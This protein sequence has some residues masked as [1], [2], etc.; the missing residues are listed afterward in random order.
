MNIFYALIAIVLVILI[1]KQIIKNVE[2]RRMLRQMNAISEACYNDACKTK[3]VEKPKYLESLTP[4]STP[5]AKKVA[6]K[7]VK[8]VSKKNSK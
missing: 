2:N 4:T 6:K 8:K 7:V 3:V 1:V 5:K